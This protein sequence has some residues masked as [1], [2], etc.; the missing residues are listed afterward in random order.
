[1]LN[2][3]EVTFGFFENDKFNS[4]S[5]IRRDKSL[6]FERPLL[7]LRAHEEVIVIRRESNASLSPHFALLLVLAHSFV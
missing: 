2:V 1:M 5:Q 7:S 6:E 3:N 4:F